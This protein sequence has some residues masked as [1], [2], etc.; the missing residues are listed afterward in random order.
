MTYN[1]ECVCIID[2]THRGVP[3]MAI[4]SQWHPIEKAQAEAVEVEDG[5]PAPVFD[6]AEAVQ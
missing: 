1:N 3:V 4:M 6:A 5:E 2:N